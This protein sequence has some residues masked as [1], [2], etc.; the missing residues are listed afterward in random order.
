LLTSGKIQH[1]L[2]TAMQNNALQEAEFVGQIA[3]LQAELHA[4]IISLMPGTEGAEDVV[5]ETNLV[6]WEKRKTFK[7]GTNF[8]AWAF[9]TARYKVMGHRRKLANLGFLIFDDDLAEQLAEECEAEPEE[10]TTRMDALK[11]CLTRLKETERQL[12]E[13]RYMADSNLDDFAQKSGRSADSLR[14]TLFRIRAGLKKC[15][16]GEL[17]IKNILS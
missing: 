6:L 16:I 17:N 12:I 9:Q 3:S 15:M 11:K 13:H 10:L 8:R 1:T 4:F 5:Q 7:P 14:V 2:V